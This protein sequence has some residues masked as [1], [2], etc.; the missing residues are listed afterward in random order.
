MRILSLDLN[1]IDSILNSNFLDEMT[2]EGGIG[3]NTERYWLLDCSKMVNIE[4]INSFLTMS[5]VNG[6]FA[7]LIKKP[8]IKGA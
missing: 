3:K 8:P 1:Q 2:A 6:F 7:I 5:R 4:N